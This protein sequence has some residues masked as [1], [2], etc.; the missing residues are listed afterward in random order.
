MAAAAVLPVLGSGAAPAVAAPAGAATS[1][2]PGRGCPLVV[3]G[4]VLHFLDDP[5]D[6][7]DPATWEL[8][9][10]GALVVGADG[11]IAWTGHARDLPPGLSAG[12]E[13][14]DHRGKLIVPGFVDTHIHAAQVDVIA[15]YGEQLLQWLDTYVFP[16]EARFDDR[17]HARA[18]SGFFLDRLLAAGTT[19]ATVFP[20]VH[21]TSVNAFFEQAEQRNLRMLC[22]KVLMDRDPY[23]PAYLRDASVAQAEWE[24]REL[25]A[26]WHGRGRLGY[27]IT[28]RFAPTSTVK[29]LTMVG[30]LWNDHPD[31]WIQTHAAENEDEVALVD[32]LFGGRSYIDVYDRHGLL[33]KKSLFAHCVH[34][35]DTD[36]TRLAEAGSAIAFCPT[37]NL[38]LGSGLFDLRAAREQKVTVGLGTDVGAGTSYSA[39]VTLNEAYKVT[40]LRGGTLSAQRGFYLATLGGAKA[41][42]LDGVIG[43]FRRGK[44][45][46]FTVLD[47]AA[48]PVLARRT[49]VSES[50]AE[51]LFA[52]MILGDERA[53]AATYVMG[54]RVHERAARG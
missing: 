52:L 10:D 12:A 29:L 48:T 39:L 43:N 41:L 24:T 38:F 45:A 36:R 37:S 35:D 3:R 5:G 14:V 17:A 26:R 44:E 33:T 20:T 47:F 46:D 9:E 16:A 31:L 30:R 15:S 32:E 8:F 27:S 19:T 22:G 54:R 42:D 23:A 40:A 2:A 53:V 11:R 1:A 50:F 13:R 34:I 6:P 7:P 18:L 49:E 25:I 21:P 51:R 4:T 28:P